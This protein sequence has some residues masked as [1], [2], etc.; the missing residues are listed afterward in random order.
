MTRD[1]RRPLNSI[2]GGVMKRAP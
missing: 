1:K 2:H